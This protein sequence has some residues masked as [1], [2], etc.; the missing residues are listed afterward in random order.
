MSIRNADGVQNCIAGF[1]WVILTLVPP[2]VLH[3][4]I[5]VACNLR[6]LHANLRAASNFEQIKNCSQNTAR[7]QRNCLYPG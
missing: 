2:A 7:K 4:A 5:C 3:N 6:I 1:Y